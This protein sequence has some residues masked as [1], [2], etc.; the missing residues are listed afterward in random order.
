MAGALVGHRLL[1]RARAGNLRRRRR[2]RYRH[3]P[4]ATTGA[5]GRSRWRIALAPA[6]SPNGCAPRAVRCR[7]CWRR[8]ARAG[9]YRRTDGGTQRMDAADGYAP[10]SPP[11]GAM[12][13]GDA[14]RGRE[15]VIGND[16]ASL[17]DVGRDVACLEFH[18]TMNTLDASVME[19]I[20]E[21]LAL[22]PD[23]FAGLVVHND[24]E[25]FCAGVNLRE[26]VAR[27]PRR[28]MGPA[29][30]R[31]R[32]R[33]EHVQGDEVRPVPRGRRAGR[34]GA[35][36]RMR[37]PAALRRDRRPRRDLCRACRGRRRPHPGLGRMQG[38]ARTVLAPGDRGTDAGWA[39][40]AGEPRV[41]DGGAREG[42]AVS[43]R[44]S[45]ARH[46]AARRRHRDE[47]GPGAWRGDRKGPHAGGRLRRARAAGVPS[48]RALGEDPRWRSALGNSCAPARRRRT[49]WWWPMPSP[50]CSLEGTRT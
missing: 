50:G 4:S 25:H 37:D 36:R 24:A 31:G 21:A 18:T 5:R 29:R 14:R 20:G 8:P 34:D 42:L 17:W 2:H 44:G 6:G 33:A 15:R 46:S 35:R 10:V 39:D 7:R 19:L 12:R 45:R 1:G 49:T 41:R 11:K 9:F 28:G 38:A 30:R 48:A 40:A 13:L 32:P 47:P 23:R 26:A 16:S 43:R 27:L 3:A 22:V